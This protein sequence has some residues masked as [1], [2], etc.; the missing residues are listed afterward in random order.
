MEMSARDRKWY[1]AICQCR[2]SGLTEIN[3]EL[4]LTQLLKHRSEYI[5]YPG[6]REEF[7]P[8]SDRMKRACAIKTEEG[9]TE[10]NE[11]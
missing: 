4:Y 6:K 11:G 5:K 3:P 7:A 10:T 9:N 8:W 1:E 2:Q